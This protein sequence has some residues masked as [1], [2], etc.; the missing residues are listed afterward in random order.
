MAS[1][2]KLQ[3]CAFFLLLVCPAFAFADKLRISSNPTGATVE[4]DGISMGTTPFE[5][6]YPGGY[7][8]KTR[9]SFGT[10]LEHPMVARIS[11]VGY[12][13]KELTLTEGPMNWVSLNGRSHGDYW[14]LKS[15]HFQVEL[16]AISE[17]F[18]GVVSA[19]VSGTNEPSA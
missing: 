6:E 2:S 16:Q 13:T 17:T 7:F 3:V 15:G 9:T 19:N 1:R 4:I 12:A 8:H 5:K 10:R 18:T 14:L 11:L